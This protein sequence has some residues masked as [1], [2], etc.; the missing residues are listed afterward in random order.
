MQPDW[1]SLRTAT[2]RVNGVGMSIGS[3][4]LL[5]QSAEQFRYSATT[6]TLE[7]GKGKKEMGWI[8]WFSIVVLVISC[9][10]G[11]LDSLGLAA[12]ATDVGTWKSYTNARFGFS[13]RY[14]S[15]WRL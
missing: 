15:D 6:G 12:Q 4:P 14:P 9:G 10:V 2:G 8:R 11:S 13:A 7:T 3:R 1:I 5:L